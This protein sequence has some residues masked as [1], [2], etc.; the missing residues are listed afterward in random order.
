MAERKEEYKNLIAKFNEQ[1]IGAPETDD[2]YE[3]LEHVFTIEEAA[4]ASKMP[5]LP[6][7]LSSISK[8][9][10]IAPHELEPKLE[11]MADKGQLYANRDG[12]EP[13]YM[14]LPLLPGLIELQLMKGGTTEKDVKLAKL[15]NKM[16]H[17]GWAQEALVI[18]TPFSR[19]VPIEEKVPGGDQV[20]PY[21]KL[22]HLIGE[23][24][25]FALATCFC[26]HE[27]ELLDKKCDKP[28]EDTCMIMGPTAKFAVERG[29]AREATK[30]EM[31]DTLEKCEEAGL[32]HCSSNVQKEINFICNCCGCCCGVLGTITKLDTPG[33]VMGSGYVA[34]VDEEACTACGVCEDRCQTYAISIED[35]AVVK[36]SKCIGCGLCVTTCPTEA[37]YLK[38]LVEKPKTPMNLPDLM[39]RQISEKKAAEKAAEQT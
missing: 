2:M 24:S 36:E 12:K 16:Y 1:P 25:Y 27:H 6:Q 9:V 13:A 34:K 31:L 26:R 38:A 22:K 21:E 14:L 32:V 37:I 30:D 5:P 7:P 11:V 20:L 17:S 18:K 33:A 39:F 15:F 35:F 3:F 28:K 8:T 29:F 23:N 10:G 19:V 4:I